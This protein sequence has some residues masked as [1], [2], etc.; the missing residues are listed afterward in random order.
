MI[1]RF[2]N[3]V[4]NRRQNSCK[5]LRNPGNPRKNNLDLQRRVRRADE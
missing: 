4:K 5:E 3:I 1:E 2:Q